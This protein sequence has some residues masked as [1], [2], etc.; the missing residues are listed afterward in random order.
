MCQTEMFMVVA[1]SIKTYLSFIIT[2][3][4]VIV[5]EHGFL[6]NGVRGIN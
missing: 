3:E 6:V 4:Y 1:H 5:I 2:L